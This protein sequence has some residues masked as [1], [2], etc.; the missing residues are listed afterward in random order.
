MYNG[1]M[2]GGRELL[3]SWQTVEMIMC[4]Y[5]CQVLPQFFVLL[6][7]MFLTTNIGVYGLIS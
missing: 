2:A 7:S 3:L 4:K 1:M 6:Y 5:T